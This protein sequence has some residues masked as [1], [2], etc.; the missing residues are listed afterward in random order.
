MSNTISA[1]NTRRNAKCRTGSPRSAVSHTVLFTT[2]LI[3]LDIN[4]AEN[5]RDPCHL[6]HLLCRLVYLCVLKVPY[7]NFKIFFGF[8]VKK[9]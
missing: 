6:E 7:F 4:T 8:W 3:Y 9:Y 5:S 2:Q 1:V